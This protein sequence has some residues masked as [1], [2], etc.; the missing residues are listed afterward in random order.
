MGLSK[1]RH[2]VGEFFL[3]AGSAVSQGYID[4]LGVS[5]KAAGRKIPFESLQIQPAL[6]QVGEQLVRTAGSV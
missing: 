3:L 4:H 5:P 6:F 1:A 2:G